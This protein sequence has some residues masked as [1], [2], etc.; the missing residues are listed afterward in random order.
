MNDIL[1]PSFLEGV[2]HNSFLP[3]KPRP[4]SLKGKNGHVV[5]LDPRRVKPLPDNPRF[6]E[7][8]GFSAES[9]RGLADSIKMI[10]QIDPVK[11][12][13]TDDPDFDAQ[14]YDGERRL[15][16]CLEAGFM[17]N[18]IVLEEYGDPDLL[19][20]R[21]VVSNYQ[22]EGHTC[23]E[24]AYSVQRF[25]DKGLTMEQIAT[26]VGKSTTWVSQHASLMRL[27]PSIRK[28]L[29]PEVLEGGETSKKAVISFQL[30]LLLVDFQREEQI[31]VAQ[32]IIEKGFSYTQARR[33]VLKLRNTSLAHDHEAQRYTSPSKDAFATLE[34]LTDSSE[35][36]FGVYLDMHP[37]LLRGAAARRTS[38]Q[39]RQ[40]AQKLRLLSSQLKTLSDVVE[41]AGAP[42][43]A[44]SLQEVTS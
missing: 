39:R 40:L 44:A 43:M 6:A 26:I 22:R 10:G 35:D 37:K 14:L 32:E 27:D 8:E 7:N 4:V 13:L 1:I 33:F 31:G 11:I 2:K 36:L 29:A 23:L 34:T 20:L 9:I 25:R 38:D 41:K 30:G 19:Y 5:A 18:G 21:S 17:I 16:A 42:K 15:R 3:E 24:A 12:C 28:L